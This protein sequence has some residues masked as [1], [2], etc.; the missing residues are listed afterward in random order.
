[1][2]TTQTFQQHIHELRTRILWVVV[3]VF[4]SGAVGFSLRNS[5]I[6][7]IQ[8]PLGAPLYYTNPAGSFNFEI[9]LSVIVSLFI[10]LPVIVYQILSFIGPALPSKLGRRVMAKVITAS[11]ALAAAGVVF[12]YYV[13]VPLSLHFFAKYSTAQLKPLISSDSYLSYLVNNLVIFA[14]VFQIPLIISFIDRIK[15]LTPRGLLRYQR[16]I[17]V[18]AFVLA[19]ILP[20][21]YD[22][23]SQFV[24]AIPIVVLY[25]LSVLMVWR[26]HQ[27]RQRGLAKQ[28]AAVVL[29]TPQPAVDPQPAPPQ[30]LIPQARTI[31][32]LDG[33][34]YRAMPQVSSD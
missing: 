7:F 15:P 13:I 5:L 28:P 10:A 21:T 29:E 31:R 8:Q 30:R 26:S 2:A 33:I 20:F 24:V 34:G 22:P 27:R 12:G 18:G 3:A 16:H 17:V 25:Y 11:V 6:N 32:R 23:I 14:L 9:K 1:V 19:L 4:V